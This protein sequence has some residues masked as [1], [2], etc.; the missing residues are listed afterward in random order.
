[1]KDTTGTY[2]VQSMTALLL[3]GGMICSIL[4]AARVYL[5]P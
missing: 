2:F 1:M 4:A 5:V 3:F